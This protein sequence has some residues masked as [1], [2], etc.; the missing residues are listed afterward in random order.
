M[1]DDRRK[2]PPIHELLATAQIQNLQTRQTDWQLAEASELPRTG[3]RERYDRD[4]RPNS[5]FAP[6]IAKYSSISVPVSK[7]SSKSVL[8]RKPLQTRGLSNAIKSTTSAGP[9]TFLSRPRHCAEWSGN[10]PATLA[11]PGPE[12]NPRAGA[13]KTAPWEDVRTA[14]FF[15]P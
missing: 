13:P 6:T 14:H 2:T 1:A 7:P 5:T 3:D 10:S 12:P 9:K 8:V 15:L 11:S 4:Q